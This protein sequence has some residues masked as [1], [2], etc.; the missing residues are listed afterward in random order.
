LSSLFNQL[1]DDGLT[2][3]R[4]LEASN[5][6]DMALKLNI[7]DDDPDQKFEYREKL[8]GVSAFSAQG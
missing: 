8:K 4:R 6:V 1:Q 7:L 5:P 3:L 2:E